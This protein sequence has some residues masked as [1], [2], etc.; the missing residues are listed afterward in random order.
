MVLSDRCDFMVFWKV[1]GP[2]LGVPGPVLGVPDHPPARQ[3]GSVWPTFPTKTQLASIKEQNR[4]KSD[5]EHDHHPSRT[6]KKNKTS[7]AARKV[8][9]TKVSPQTRIPP[10]GFQRRSAAAC[11]GG[12]GG[13]CDKCRLKQQH[14]PCDLTANCRLR[15]FRVTLASPELF[16]WRRTS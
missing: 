10:R 4:I 7:T 2:V 13:E 15:W 16:S 3:G 14:L 5:L 9:L 8:Q 1:P 11:F 12:G 6:Q